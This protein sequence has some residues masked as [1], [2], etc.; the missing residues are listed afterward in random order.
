M[1]AVL[2]YV[3]L[4]YPSPLSLNLAV[5]SQPAPHRVL[6]WDPLPHQE[7][8]LCLQ[9]GLP[10]EHPRHPVLELFVPAKVQVWRAFLRKAGVPEGDAGFSD[11][12]TQKLPVPRAQYQRA[13]DQECV[14]HGQVPRLQ[15]KRAGRIFPSGGDDERDGRV[16]GRVFC[17]G[18]GVIS[19]G[20][21]Y[22]G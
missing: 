15:R 17:A 7:P 13:P 1:V 20:C 8:R 9:R 19:E 16:H 18:K 6:W 11:D 4:F 3:R 5:S 2:L 12:L 14:P 10:V 21:M 22:D